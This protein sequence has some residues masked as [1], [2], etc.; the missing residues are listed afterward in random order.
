MFDHFQIDMLRVK[1]QNATH[2]ANFDSPSVF[3]VTQPVD[4]SEGPIWDGRKS[5]LYFVDIH[6]GRVLSYNYNTKK[7]NFITLKGAVTPVIPA[8]NNE[9][10]LIVG[11][12]RSLVALEWDGEK[13]LG[14]QRTL[15]T[16]S[17]QFPQSR[18][19]DGK[20][21]KQGRV[22]IGTMGFENPQ[23]RSL[24]ANQGMLYKMTKDTLISPKVEVAP[25][26]I[27]NGLCWNK[28]NNKMYYIDSPTRKVVE[29]DF[30]EEK[31]DISNPRIAVDI[32][33]FP[34][35]TGNPDG[36]TID[37]DD[38]LWIALY[39]GGSVIKANPR[40]GQL[41]QVV[42]I[43]ARDVTSVIWGGP[44]L[45][46]LFVTTSRFHL[47]DTERKMYPAAGSVFAVTNLNQKGLVPNFAD[48]VNSVRR[49]NLI[50]EIIL[51]TNELFAPTVS[52]EVV[53]Y[54]PVSSN[55][56][57]NPQT[58]T[59]ERADVPGIKKSLLSIMSTEFDGPSI[60]QVSDPV[61]MG[62]SPVW[63]R[64]LGKLLFVDIHKGR[65]MAYDFEKKTTDIAAEFPGHDLTPIILYKNSPNVLVAGLGRN[66][67][68][69][70][71]YNKLADPEILHTVQHDKPKNRFN[72]GKADSRGRVWIGTIG[73]EPSRGKLDLNA[74]ALFKFTK[75]N[76]TNPTVMIPKVSVSNGI[77]WNQD[78]TELYYIDTPSEE[79][80]KYDYYSESGNI[81]NKTVV[82]STKG[83]GLG[84]PDGMTID[85][86]GNLWVALYA[87]GSVIQINPSNRT[88]IRRIPIPAQFTTSVA[89]GGP[90]LDVLFVTTARRYLTP[91]EL[92]GQPGAGSLYAI[93]GLG[94]RGLP[95]FE[96]DV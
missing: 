21:D 47:S 4:H 35:V 62:E 57:N 61:T 7:V 2:A 59:V 29:Y 91:E 36:M 89:W 46:I 42:P 5:I 66:L 77:A 80:V 96:A 54:A 78:G 31:G 9:N 41:L 94:T 79:I 27:S 53:S 82:F 45:D 88:L 48:L 17:Q 39:Y 70:A 34:Y 43:P 58:R 68:K 24:D 84:Y 65:V 71:L 81:A 74:A 15:T 87:G 92:Q 32:T 1:S 37:Q 19:N 20:A 13:E 22:W 6:S 30:D 55:T 3:Q 26:N 76:V 90:N 38:N 63:D 8:K 75:G 10:I 86:D 95:D 23:T 52:N 14:S 28:A 51:N 18:F 67:A 69:I 83:K 72:D 33:K 25:V 49:A 11:V 44:N 93:T 50:A 73:D 16:V 40:N 60:I 56:N 12:D 85:E 64:R